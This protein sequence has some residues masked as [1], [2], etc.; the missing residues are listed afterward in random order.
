MP[1]VFN[2]SSFYGSNHFL[3]YHCYLHYK[4]TLVSIDLKHMKITLGTTVL[5]KSTI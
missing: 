3:S 2:Q 5:K 4:M 1:G